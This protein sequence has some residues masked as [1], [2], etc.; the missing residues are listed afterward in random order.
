MKPRVGVWRALAR[1]GEYKVR[2]LIWPE[3]VFGLVLGLG[4]AVVIVH[5]TKLPDRLDVVGDVLALSG[6]LLAVVFTALA[7]VVSIPS[8]KYIR[9]LAET[10][11]GGMIR[12]LDP[13][14]IAVGT[15]AAII[16]LALAYKLAAHDVSRAIEH[17]A[18]YAMGFLL[19]FGLL[20]VVALARSL[21]RHGVNRGIEALNSAE[22]AGGAGAVPRLD[23]RR[24]GE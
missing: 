22:D 7:L 20:D 16:V 13:F 10:P 21:V 3:G 18:F 8:E 17:S 23:Q 9:L 19:V 6:A 4:G 14:L 11:N 15:Q 5:A 24:R 2:E 1:L 12:F